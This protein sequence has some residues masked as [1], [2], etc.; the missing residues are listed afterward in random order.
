MRGRKC[1][2]KM[3]GIPH[4]RRARAHMP[5]LEILHVFKDQGKDGMVRD[6]E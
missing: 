5:W 3:E 2:W 6:M 4:S 1:E